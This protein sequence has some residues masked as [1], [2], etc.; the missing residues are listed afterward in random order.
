VAR[1]GAATLV[2]NSSIEQKVP[3]GNMKDKPKRALINY[4]YDVLCTEDN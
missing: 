4:N 2:G 1:L 3:L